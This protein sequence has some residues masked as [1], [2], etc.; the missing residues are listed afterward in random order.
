MAL[1]NWYQGITEDLMS[2]AGSRIF[3]NMLQFSISDI[4][5]A[6]KRVRIHTEPEWGCERLLASST[7]LSSDYNGFASV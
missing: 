7:E 4:N 6:N 1:K 2:G 5:D 3:F